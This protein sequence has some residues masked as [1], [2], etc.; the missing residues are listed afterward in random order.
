MKYMRYS[1]CEL[2]N[3]YELI[4]VYYTRAQASFI[5]FFVIVIFSV[6]MSVD[7]MYCIVILTKLRSKIAVQVRLCSY[8][9]MA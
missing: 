5:T 1:C 8:K 6:C 3:F 4:A 2:E 9:S 7:L